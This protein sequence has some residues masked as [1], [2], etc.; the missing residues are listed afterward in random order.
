MSIT[1][2]YSDMEYHT[3]TQRG[4]MKISRKVHFVVPRRHRSQKALARAQ[5][6][7]PAV[8]GFKLVSKSMAVL[9]LPGRWPADNVYWYTLMSCIFW[10][11]RSN[12][13]TS[14]K[15]IFGWH[16]FLNSLFSAY[17]LQYRRVNM[18]IPICDVINRN[19]DVTKLDTDNIL[20]KCIIHMHVPML[21]QPCWAFEQ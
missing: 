8:Q 16:T 12:A 9:E 17:M 5:F 6:T 14:E 21:D 10:P 7:I 13:T 15:P 4:H 1:V 11:H 2:R 19:F 18:T 3:H 20:R